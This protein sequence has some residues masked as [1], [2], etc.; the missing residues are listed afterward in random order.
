MESNIK[1]SVQN[2]KKL[3]VKRA[4]DFIKKEQ[5]IRVGLEEAAR[6]WE[7]MNETLKRKKRK[8][9]K[10]GEVRKNDR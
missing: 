3:H 5:A 1:K 10:Q 2:C 7:K 9:Q 4:E 8:R 6:M